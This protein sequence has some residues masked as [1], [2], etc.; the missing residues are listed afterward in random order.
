MCWY[1]MWD[2]GDLELLVRWMGGEEIWEFYENMVENMV[3]MQVFD[4][5]E[6]FYVYEMCLGV[7]Y[8]VKILLFKQVRLFFILF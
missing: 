1:R 8:V 7:G 3:E 4:E 6:Y 5:Y 2:D